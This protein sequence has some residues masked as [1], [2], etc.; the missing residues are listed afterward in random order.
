MPADYF[1]EEEFQTQFNGKTFRRILSLIV[2]HRKWAIGFLI[3]I[4]LVAAMDAIF[5]YLSKQIIDQGI[6]QH[7][8]QAVYQALHSATRSP[9]FRNSKSSGYERN[10]RQGELHLCAP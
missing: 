6:S 2:P 10:L 1:E 4:T 9:A 7:N 8:P 5:T 3:T